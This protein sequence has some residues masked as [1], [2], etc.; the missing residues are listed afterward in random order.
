MGEE[1]GGQEGALK[2]RTGGANLGS[3]EEEKMTAWSGRV[4]RT[5]MRGKRG[6][7][8]DGVRACGLSCEDIEQAFT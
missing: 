3:A 1:E 7:E 2:A 6:R 8:E 5:A 4:V